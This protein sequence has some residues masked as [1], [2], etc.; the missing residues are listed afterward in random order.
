ARTKVGELYKL[1]Q[2]LLRY[3]SAF[4]ARS[5][6]EAERATPRI[7]GILKAATG[8]ATLSDWSSSADYQN[9]VEAFTESLRTASVFDAVL[10]DGMIK[11]PLRSR[12]LTVTTG[13]TGAVVGEGQA[14]GDQLARARLG[15]AR[16]QEGRGDSD[17]HE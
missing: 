8:A 10:A 11:A 7:A 3:K 15:V 1:A 4:N 13:I 6:V 16:A 9:I 17:R 5:M 12:G 14:K 2:M